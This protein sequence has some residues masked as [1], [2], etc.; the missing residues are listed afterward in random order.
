MVENIQR[1]LENLVNIKV[2]ENKEYMIKYISK[3]DALSPLKTLTRGYSIV[4]D[5]NNKVINT[6]T[7]LNT[8]DIIKIRL[9]DGEKETKVL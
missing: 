3:L 7:K 2:K 6:V 1:K 9:K 4:M 5:N 8:G